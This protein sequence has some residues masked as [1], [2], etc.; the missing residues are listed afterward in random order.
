MSEWDVILRTIVALVA[1]G[2]IGIERS[3]HGRAAGLR[4]YA[5]VCFA[6]ALLVAATQYDISAQTHGAGEITRVIQG[7]V[8]GIGFLGAG[9]I[10]KD[11]YSVRGL[12]TSAS[13]WVA[14]AIGV[15]IGAGF[16]LTGI[17]G[18]VA[19]LIALALFRKLEDRLPTQ[20]FV[21][22]EMGFQREQALDETQFRALVAGH[23]FKVRELAYALRESPPLVE[24]RTVIWT[25][26]EERV[27]ALEKDL[28][29][30]PEVVHFRLDPSRD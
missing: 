30:R 9:V 8:T 24:Y 12:T 29:G 22:L 11:G 27:S 23:G 14:S 18:A 19:T 3:Y 5:L 7:I 6:S 4:T 25:D 28:L 26:D 13:I 20:T 17:V 21:H 10:I 15:V 16:Y 2:S 1:G